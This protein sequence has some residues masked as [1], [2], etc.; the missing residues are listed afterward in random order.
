MPPS[1]GERKE[2]NRSAEAEIRAI[3]AAVAAGE[4]SRGLGQKYGP[5]GEMHSVTTF[6][7]SETSDRLMGHTQT[8]NNKINVN[9]KF[10][11]RFQLR[12]S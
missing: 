10:G 9:R 5:V 8:V 7:T 11:I 4:V 12:V 6:P 3:L 1:R 2:H